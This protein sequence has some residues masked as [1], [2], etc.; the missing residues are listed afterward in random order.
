MLDGLMNKSSEAYTGRRKKE[1][2]YKM[3]NMERLVGIDGD[4]ERGLR[5]V[6]SSSGM[7]V[8]ACASVRMYVCMFVHLHTY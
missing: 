3:S 1:L 4:A 6:I 8:C 5:V 7:E 2:C